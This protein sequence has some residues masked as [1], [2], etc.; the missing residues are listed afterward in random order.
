MKTTSPPAEPPLAALPHAAAA[1][2]ALQPYV[3]SYAGFA[4]EIPPGE[5]LCARVIPPGVPVM[6]IVLSGQIRI[7]DGPAAGQFAPPAGLTGQL[8]RSGGT[9]CAGALECFAVHFAPAGVHDLLGVSVAGLQN[10][11]VAAAEVLG[12]GAETYLQALRTAP[13]FAARGRLSD[14]FFAGWLPGAAPGLGAAAAGLL[15]AR[16]GLLDIEELALRL[17]VSE[18]TLLRRFRHEV[19]LSPKHFARLMRFRA[20]HAYLQDPAARW[21]DAVLRFGY[22]DQ[23]H[24]I[25]DYRDFAGETPRQYSTEARVLDR[26]VSLVGPP[27]APPA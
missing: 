9:A 4:L 8:T 12:P 7:T 23:S 1:A 6:T 20:A 2:A 21:A 16:Q 19:G 27:P 17:G 3:S 15:Q 5:E 25:R 18:R 26:S 10:A 11:T 13:D 24:L 22:T 14:E